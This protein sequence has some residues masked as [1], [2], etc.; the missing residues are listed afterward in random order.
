MGRESSWSA[1]IPWT[2]RRRRYVPAK[3]LTISVDIFMLV[4]TGRLPLPRYL[5]GLYVLKSR[6]PHELKVVYV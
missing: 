5:R 2:C 4:F 3:G 6:P 1:G